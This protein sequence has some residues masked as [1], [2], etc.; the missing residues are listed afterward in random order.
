MIK[1]FIITAR[2]EYSKDSETKPPRFCEISWLFNELSL[3]Q[4][5]LELLCQREPVAKRECQRGANTQEERRADVAG[6]NFNVV[7]FGF[8]FLFLF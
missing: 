5:Q 8:F 1:Y 6:R 7:F 3:Y 2:G 4:K